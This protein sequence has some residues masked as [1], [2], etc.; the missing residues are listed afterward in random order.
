MLSRFVLSCLVTLAS[1]LLLD[2]IEAQHATSWPTPGARVHLHAHNAYPESGRWT[3]RLDRARAAGARHLAIEQDLVWVPPGNGRRGRSVVAH[4]TPATGGEPTLEEHFFLRVRPQVEAALR[5]GREDSWPVLVL[6]LDFKTNEPEHH[7]DVWDLLG[8][9]ESWLT[10]AIRTPD[11]SPPSPLRKGPLLVLTEQGVGQESAFHLSRP[12]GTTLRIFGTVP[13]ADVEWPS[14]PKARSAMLAELAVDRLVPSAATSYRRWT[15]HAWG[16]VERDGARGAG[17]WTEADDARLGAVVRRAHELGLWIRVYGLN[18]HDA[19]G[20]GWSASY[21]FGTLDAARVRW[22]AA[23]AH[24][25]DF[26]ATDQYE[27]LARELADPPRSP[28]PKS[29]AP[30]TGPSPIARKMRR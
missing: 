24:G 12:M 11:G 5:E 16:V 6:H 17:A 8:K 20:D 1:L 26:I 3:D 30:V 21:N 29:A 14:D 23:I 10:T 28:N 13:P 9:Y 27:A 15:N 19:P 18:G 22:R 4:D 2:R 25:V 7:R